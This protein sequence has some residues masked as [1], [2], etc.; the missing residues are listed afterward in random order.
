MKMRSIIQIFHV[1]KIIKLPVW[2]LDKRL[3][4]TRIVS[5]TKQFLVLF[6]F[7]VVLLW[8]FEIELFYHSTDFNWILR[9]T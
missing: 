8:I 2:N 9:Y 1:M 4:L 6:N 5:D 3:M 7:V